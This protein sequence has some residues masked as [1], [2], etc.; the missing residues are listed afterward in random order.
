MIFR[1]IRLA[2]SNIISADVDNYLT[3]FTLALASTFKFAKMPG[4]LA[5]SKQWT[6]V[7]LVYLFSRS[8]Q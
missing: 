6:M 5:P 8:V 4:D 2:K 7:G 1:D 3:E